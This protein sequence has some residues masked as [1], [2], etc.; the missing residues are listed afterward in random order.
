MSSRSSSTTSAE[1][2]SCCPDGSSWKTSEWPSGKRRWKS[3]K[4]ARSWRAPSR[5]SPTMGSLL[6]W[7]GSMVWCT[8]R[9]SPGGEWGIRQSFSD[10][11]DKIRVKILH[12]DREKERVS[13]GIKQLSPDPWTEAEQQVSGGAANQ[14]TRGKPHG[15]RRLCGG[16]RGRGGI[17]SYFGD[18]LD[19]EGQAPFPTGQ[20]WGG[21]G[22]HGPQHR[23]R[24]TN[25]S[26]WE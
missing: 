6:I 10:V 1:G 5:T 23:C 9:T 16:R 11:S 15:L 24:P 26:P 20:G 22:D 8:S 3:W 18:V 7:A 25:E 2:T 14:G 13:L 19:Q 4:K 21:S 12:F 17:D